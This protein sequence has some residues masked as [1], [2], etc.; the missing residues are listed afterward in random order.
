MCFH[1]RID[2]PNTEIETHY[3][4]SRPEKGLELEEELL[5]HHLDGFKHQDFWVIP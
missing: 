4:F 3:N 2:R 1:T 5:Y